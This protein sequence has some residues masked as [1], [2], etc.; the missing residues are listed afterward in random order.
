MEAQR[1]PED[2]DGI[3]LGD[4]AI[5]VTD[6]AV[7]S[8]REEQALTVNP[9]AF[10]RRL[11]LPALAK[12]VLKQCAAREGLATDPFVNDPRDCHFDPAIIRCTGADANSCLTTAQVEAV[13]KIYSGPIRPEDRKVTISRHRAR[14]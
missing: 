12:A 14:C 1:Y 6:N 5:F 11:K 9:A 4:P 7:A 8:A 2:F 13:R 10:F 3:V